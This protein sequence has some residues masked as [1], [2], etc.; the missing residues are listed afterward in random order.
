MY[1]KNGE[2]LKIEDSC[3]LD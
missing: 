2:L 1:L 3:I